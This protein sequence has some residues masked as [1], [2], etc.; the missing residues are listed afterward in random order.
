MEKDFLYCIDH[1]KKLCIVKAHRKITFQSSVD[2]M[3]RL[4][5]A[6]DFNKKYAI[7]VDLRQI[8]Y[9]PSY[10]ELIGIK[11]NLLFLK[12]S[13][14]NKVALVTPGSLALLGELVGIFSKRENM[15]VKSFTK[16]NTAIEWLNI[17][18]KEEIERISQ[19]KF[20]DL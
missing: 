18:D 10:S 9:I 4:A 20:K 12:K 15:D 16:I 17:N 7:L 19:L 5:K 14:R 8:K 13:F 11:D 1:D 6:P 2:A 3:K